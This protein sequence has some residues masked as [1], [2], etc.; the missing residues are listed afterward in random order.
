MNL[1]VSR[2]FTTYHII[3]IH[4]QRIIYA[5]P[6]ISTSLFFLLPRLTANKK[7]L[8]TEDSVSDTHKKIP[9]TCRYPGSFTRFLLQFLRAVAFFTEQQAAGT[10]IIHNETR[11]TPSPAFSVNDL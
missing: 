6:T 7:A 11:L 3:H 10:L 8:I 1:P 4:N 9:D 2:P 5:H